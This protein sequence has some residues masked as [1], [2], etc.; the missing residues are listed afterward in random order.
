MDARGYDAEGNVGIKAV[1]VTANSPN[2]P[3]TNKTAA[4]PHGLAAVSYL[5]HPEGLEPSTF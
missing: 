4:K 5:I 3:P 1:T 2:A